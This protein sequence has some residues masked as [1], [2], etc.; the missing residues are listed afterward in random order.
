MTVFEQILES[1]SVEEMAL[2][3]AGHYLY[4][5]EAY[6]GWL[7]SPAYRLCRPVY[8]MSDW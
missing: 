4:T 2:I 5:K 3:L 8:G 1:K 6:V 7:N